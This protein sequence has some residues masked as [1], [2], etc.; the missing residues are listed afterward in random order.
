MI[1]GGKTL[2]YARDL[3]KHLT[4]EAICVIKNVNKTCPLLIKK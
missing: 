3:D 2:K 1:K 4:K